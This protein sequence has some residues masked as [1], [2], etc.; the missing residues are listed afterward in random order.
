MLQV[1]LFE[2]KPSM[3]PGAVHVQVHLRVSTWTLHTVFQLQQTQ[4]YPHLHPNHVLF[5]T[6][7]N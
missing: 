3:I 6:Q 1:N 7:I 2:I 5:C 4:N